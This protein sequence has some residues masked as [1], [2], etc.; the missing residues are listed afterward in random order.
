MLF[1]YLLFLFFSYEIYVAYHY[2]HCLF[3]WFW[4][5]NI[6]LIYFLLTVICLLIW[7]YLPFWSIVPYY[8]MDFVNFAYFFI[9]YLLINFCLLTFSFIFAHFLYIPRKVSN[10]FI[11]WFLFFLSLFIYFFSI[12][13]FLFVVSFHITSLTYSFIHLFL[14]ISYTC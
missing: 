6:S 2:Y 10:S 11:D 12:S 9:L 8:L 3:V 7:C 13:L 1:I 5:F 4:S 14:C